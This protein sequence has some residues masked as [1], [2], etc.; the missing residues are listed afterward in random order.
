VIQP[1]SR[2]YLSGEDVSQAIIDAGIDLRPED[3]GS[4]KFSQIAE[5]LNHKMH[6][7]MKHEIENFVQATL[8]D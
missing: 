1:L 7:R 3:C 2:V 6:R 4:S 5:D 8:W